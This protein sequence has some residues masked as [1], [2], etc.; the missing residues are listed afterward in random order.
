MDIIKRNH[1]IEVNKELAK[2][3]YQINQLVPYPLSDIQIEDIAKSLEE[4]VPE[5]TP[6]QLKKMIDRFKIGYYEWDKTKVIQNIFKNLA[7]T[8]KED[9]VG[10]DEEFQKIMERFRK[11]SQVS[12]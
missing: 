11:P 8:M 6:M 12:L 2:Q 1:L 5:L 3:V 9:Y 7:N 10:K 4:L